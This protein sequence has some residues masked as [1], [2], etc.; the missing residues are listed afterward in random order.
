MV[1]DCL[2][3]VLQDL[4]KPENRKVHQ[5]SAIE[6]TLRNTKRILK[7]KGLVVI[8]TSMPEMLTES[9][10]YTQIYPPIAE[11][12]AKYFPTSNDWADLFAKCGFE[13]VS[14]INSLIPD[15]KKHFD[16]EGPL[17]E[18]WRLGS[19]VYACADEDEKKALLATINDLNENGLMKKFMED[20]DRTSV[21]GMTTFY[22]IRASS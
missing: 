20:H 10:W 11:K 5:W 12:L 22:I 2:F 16:P 15:M 8:L 3:Q 18:E 19:C 9:I 17:R 14:A 21:M 7:H 6:T 4:E 1:V 13:V